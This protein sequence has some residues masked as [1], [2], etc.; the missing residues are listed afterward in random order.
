MGLVAKDNGGGY[1]PVEA[2]VYHAICYGVID[3]GTQFSQIYNNETRKVLLQWELP[4]ERIE[5]KGENLPRAI[6]RQFTLSLNKK[7]TLRQF[8]ESWR[9]RAF[10]DTEL[11]GF[12]L[13]NL[14]GVNCQLNII[15]SNRNGKT[16]ADVSTATPLLKGTEKRALENAPLFFS[17]DDNMEVPEHCP[18]W[19]VERLQKSAEMSGRSGPELGK[20]DQT[21]KEDDI[22]F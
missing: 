20:H 5:I 18:D 4:T 16:Y 15:H 11:Q 7:A 8:L 17:F 13:K 6:S 14:I 9:G 2:G 21:G 12:D 19:V 3:L 10:S 22:P 1:D